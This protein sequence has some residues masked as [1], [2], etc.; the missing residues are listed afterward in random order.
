MFTAPPANI[1][2]SP[3]ENFVNL[4]WVAK[5]RHRNVGFQIYYLKKNGIV[6]KYSQPFKTKNLARE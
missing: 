5:K 4:S 3:G 2:L 6:H 1:E